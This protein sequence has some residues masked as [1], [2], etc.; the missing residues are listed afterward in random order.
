MCFLVTRITFRLRTRLKL[1]MPLARFRIL[2]ALRNGPYGVENLNR[3]VEEIL[4]EAGLIH[5]DGHFYAG[6]PVMV[7][8]NDYNL[9]LFNGDIGFVRMNETKE[10][11]ACFA[12]PEANPPRGHAAA[13]A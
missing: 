13:P 9:K 5:A 1:S 2:C 3:L 12:G 7:V 10:L 6:R 8:R 4:S 11:R